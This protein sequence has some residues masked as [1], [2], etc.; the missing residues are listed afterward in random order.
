MNGWWLV[1]ELNRIREDFSPNEYLNQLEQLGSVLI[2][3]GLITPML[4]HRQTLSFLD[5]FKGVE[6]TAWGWPKL[7]EIW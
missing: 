7:S 4:H 2:Y 6:I 1:A 5:I 3:E